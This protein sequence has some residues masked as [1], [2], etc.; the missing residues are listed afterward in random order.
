MGDER[1]YYDLRL[2]SED[3][4]LLFRDFMKW[5]ETTRNQAGLSRPWFKVIEF[6]SGGIDCGHTRSG[7]FSLFFRWLDEYVKLIGKE[8]LFSVPREM[9]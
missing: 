6:W 2:P 5:I 9:W 3:G 1:G 8:G 4:R 7:A